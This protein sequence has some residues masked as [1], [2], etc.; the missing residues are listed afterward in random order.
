MNVK[1][2]LKEKKYLL[3][4][5]LTIAGFVC[6]PL[7]MIQVLMLEKTSQGYVE[8][9]EEVI[10]EK[11][12]ETVDLFANWLEQA[13]STSIYASHDI[14]I[15]SVAKNKP[16][17]YTIYE[18]ALK[19]KEYSNDIWEMGIWFYDN[20]CVLFDEVNITPQRLYERLADENEQCREE[21]EAFFEM[22]GDD[23]RITSTAEYNENGLI[24]VAKQISFFTIRKYDATV[25]FVIKEE[26][27]EQIYR[28]KFQN[29]VGMAMVDVEGAFCGKSRIFTEEI[30]EKKDFVEFLKDDYQIIYN[31]LDK[32]K[33][34]NIYK[35]VDQTLG[36]TTLVCIEQ[37]D[38]E[39]QLEQYVRNIRN[40]ILLSVVLMCFL[41]G[42][43]VHINY[44]P[45]KKL[46]IKH[47]NNAVSEGLSEL[48]LLD[49]SF[50]WVNQKILNQK[51]LLKDFVIGDLLRGKTVDVQ[52]VKESFPENVNGKCVVMALTGP[53]INSMQVGEFVAAIKECCGCDVYVT[54]ITYR[55]RILLICVL[56]PD[57]GCEALQEYIRE[58]L[59]AVT[60]NQYH[61]S[62]GCVVEKIED[63]R[64]SY[65]KTL[66]TAN[67]VDEDTRDAHAE[68]KK[69]IREFGEEL[70]GGN[71]S[72]IQRLL[73]NVESQLI[74]LDLD[75]GHK[76]YYCYNLLTV[77]FA[78]L[79]EPFVLDDE[80]ER[81]FAFSDEKQLFGMLHQFV[82]RICALMDE[83]E[84]SAADLMKKELL[85]YVEAH[86][87]DPNLSQAL[88]ADHLKT[89]VYVV[90]RLFKA[91][92]GKGY[93]E[94][95]MEMRLEHARKLLRVSSYSVTEISVMSGFVK[96]EYFSSVFKE[97]YGCAPTK[98]RE[99]YMDKSD[100]SVV[101]VDDFD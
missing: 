19:I 49:S 81:L 33:E 3:R 32:E 26:T 65:L 86:F 52:L 40:V 48:E 80:M 82:K 89:S 25:F 23:M 92:T 8:V 99:S 56:R 101:K 58:G 83:K 91:T 60:N 51:K 18:T 62:C 21:I 59:L 75:D 98:Y 57:I 84:Q 27:L 4:L 28:T 72:N 70:P 9:N 87:N 44:K 64:K 39:K 5:Y 17:K 1:K 74:S 93:R 46:I 63:I 20:N 79:K 6:I 47:Q 7:L 97:R 11:L 94:Y 66:K 68:L 55:P 37:D 43:T 35:Y 10:F 96:Q 16:S 38:F 41:L 50:L 2:Y 71:S 45:I 85:D 53:V 12:Q 36:Y 31:G 30:C 22:V 73:E 13:S 67:E 15:R 54:S 90:S 14:I 88:V 95:V 77:C 24:I 34:T 76:K 61:I 78:N 29:Y 100:E 42:I 69:A